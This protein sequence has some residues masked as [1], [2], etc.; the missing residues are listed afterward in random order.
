[1]IKSSIEYAISGTVVQEIDG[2]E[3]KG[4]MGNLKDFFETQLAVV[5]QNLA[6]SGANIGKRKL[7]AAETPW[8]RARMS[9]DY[10][11]VR[12]KP[13]GRSAGREDTGNMYDS[14]E[15][16]LLPSNTRTSSNRFNGYFGWR[17]ETIRKDPYILLQAQGF[18]SN[19]SF[20]PVATAASGIAKFKKGPEKFVQGAFPLS[21]AYKSIRNRA[22]S[23]YSAAWNEA[24]KQWN[25]NGFKG[26]PGS[27]LD[28]RAAKG[29]VFIG[30][31]FNLRDLGY[32][33]R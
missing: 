24:V 30:T 12:F 18:R 20:D 32:P 9:G 4:R 26:N 22:Q 8:G 7:R 3:M 33:V 1:M 31:P 13:Y 6:Q 19:G 23:A 11:G 14:L 16:W 27:Y 15:A 25:A 29:N 10:G 2:P 21:D 17:P 5:T 28:R